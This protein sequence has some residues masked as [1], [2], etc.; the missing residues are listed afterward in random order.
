[1]D[2]YSFPGPRL[3]WDL[4][5]AQSMHHAPIGEKQK[6]GMGRRV[7]QVGDDITFGEFGGFHAP[8]TPPLGPV[9]S[10]PNRFDISTPRDRDD[11]LF[12]GNQV[13]DGHLSQVWDQP[14]AAWCGEL[15]F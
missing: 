15:L 13:L 8:T 10:S 4:V 14:T 1:M 11:Q 12:I 3:A 5:G 7:D 9:G 6:V 2:Q